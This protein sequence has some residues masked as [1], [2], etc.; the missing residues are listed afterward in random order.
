[1]YVTQSLFVYKYGAFIWSEISS[2]FGDRGVKKRATLKRSHEH[3]S[4]S[5]KYIG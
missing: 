3:I 2:I 5:E 1:M 4:N